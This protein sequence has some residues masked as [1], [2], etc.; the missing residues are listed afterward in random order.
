MDAKEF[1][2]RLQFVG[3]LLA[4]GKEVEFRHVL[5]STSLV[6]VN[7]DWEDLSDNLDWF[8]G[9]WE[10]VEFREKPRRPLEKWEVVDSEGRIKIYEKQPLS[11]FTK[12]ALEVI[13]WREVVSSEPLI[14][15]EED[16]DNG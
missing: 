12:N 3:K 10:T 13:H 11:Q 16:S 1:G 8:I 7:R 2:K 14:D 6:R 9:Q 4:E 5:P 15:D